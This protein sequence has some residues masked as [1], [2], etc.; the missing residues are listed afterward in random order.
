MLGDIRLDKL[1]ADALDAAY[2]RW[3]A[4]GLSPATVHKYHS[5]L[6][7]A[8]RQAVKWGWIDSAPTDRATPPSVERKE[9]VVPTPGAAVRSS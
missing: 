3:L 9:M 2:R 5:I 4:E 7:A 8:C 6:S 1:D